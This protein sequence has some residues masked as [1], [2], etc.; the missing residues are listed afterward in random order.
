[1]PDKRETELY[2]S[3][4]AGDRKAFD[5]LQLLMDAPVRHYLRRLVGFIDDEDEIVQDVFLA[6]YTNLKRIRSSDS[7]RPFLFRIVRN[8]CYDEIRRKRRFKKTDMPEDTRPLPSAFIDP[9]PQPDEEAYWLLIYSEV[10]RVIDLLPEQQRQVFILYF[11]ENFSYA[12][13]AE[14]IGT[15]IGTIKSRFHYGRRALLKR[16]KPEVR[17]ALDK[18]SKG[19]SS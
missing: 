3:A 4:K 16:L 14:A 6:L 13:I 11:E 12:Q 1:M 18:S 7:M 19:A 5:G 10:Q 15:D 9:N 17:A 8:R 2:Q